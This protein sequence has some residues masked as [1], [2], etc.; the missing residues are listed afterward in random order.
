M[1]DTFEGKTEEEAIAKGVANGVDEFIGNEYCDDDC[2]GW[3]G[4]DRRCYCGNRRVSWQTK[5]YSDGT[6]HAW[7]EAW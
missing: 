7:A 1:T 4:E 6:W 2:F 5:Q 3:D